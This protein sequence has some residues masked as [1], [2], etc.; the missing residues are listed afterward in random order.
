MGAIVIW[1]RYDEGTESAEV[2]TSAIICRDHHP[3]MFHVNNG[4]D[5]FDLYCQSIN[6]MKIFLLS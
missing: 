5:I 6:K 1:T 3:L 4:T 2:V